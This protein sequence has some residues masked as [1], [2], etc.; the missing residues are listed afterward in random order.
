MKYRHEKVR[1]YLLKKANKRLLQ[2]VR[3]KYETRAAAASTKLR[4]KGIFL[5]KSK[6]YALLGIN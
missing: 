4:F 3:T 6:A 2:G 5:S 1:R